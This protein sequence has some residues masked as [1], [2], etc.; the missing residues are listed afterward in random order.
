MSYYE[1]DN[2]ATSWL[3]KT[4]TAVAANRLTNSIGKYTSLTASGTTGNSP[5]TDIDASGITMG[6]I[7]NTTNA[8]VTYGNLV[9]IY[10]SG[11]GQIIFGWSGTD[12]TT[13][14]IWYRSH[15]DTSTGGYGVWKKIVFS[16]DTIPFDKV[17]SLGEAAKYAVKTL[18]AVGTAGWTTL[19]TGQTTI[20]DMAFIAYWNGAYT[21]TSSNLAYCK[22]GAFGTIVTKSADDYLG[23]SAT[24][25][26]ATKLATARTI[27][28]NL[29][30][31]T[32][33]SFDGTNNINPGVTGILP[34]ANGGLGTNNAEVAR[35]N[36]VVAPVYMDGEPTANTYNGL[37]WIGGGS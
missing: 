34:F 36:L 31:T 2:D 21:G 24:A 33:A 10:G 15:R 35:K 3:A 37:I 17:A 27:Q 7:S 4:G 16:D 29:A 28:V 9:N 8:P 6:T 5:S 23:K 30:S 12:S 18:T 20:P 11:S 26:S 25:A 1:V 22:H 32:Y 13:E 14:H 19:A